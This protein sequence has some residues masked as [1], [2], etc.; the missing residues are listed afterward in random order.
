MEIPALLF[1]IKKQK[2][3]KMAVND[4]FQL[5]DGKKATSYRNTHLALPSAFPNTSPLETIYHIDDNH[6]NNHICNL[7]W[8]S[9]SE[10]SRKGQKKS[11]NES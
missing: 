2:K 7:R 9:R 3:I 1:G 8:L 11:V 5:W 6:T 10:N 4:E